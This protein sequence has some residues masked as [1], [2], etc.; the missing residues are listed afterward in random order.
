VKVQE[1]VATSLTS[2]RQIPDTRECGSVPELTVQSEWGGVEL[3]EAVAEE[4]RQLCLEG[5]C[6]QPF[7]RPEWIA[8][9]IRAFAGQQGLLLITARNGD[10]LRAVLP[11]L[12]HRGWAYG[13][14]CVRLRTA[15]R[16]PRFEFVHG[17][18]DGSEAVRAV[19]QHLR[20]LPGWDVIELVNVPEGGAAERLLAA[21]SEDAFP[22]S[23]HEY[24]LSPYIPLKGNVAGGDF[25]RFGR[26]SRFRYQLRQKWRELGELGALRL[27]RTDKADPETLQRFYRL[28]QS[29]WKGREGSAILCKPELRQFYD[30]VARCAEKFGYLSIYFLELGDKDVAAHFALTYGGGYYPI[31]VAYD[32]K[33]SKYG[34]GHLIIGSVLN[35][36]VA[37]GLS[38]FDCLGEKNAALTKWTSAVHVYNSCSIFRNSVR[39]RMLCAASGLQHRSKQAL[40]TAIRS[41]R[42]LASRTKRWLSGPPESRPEK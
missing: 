31:K 3:V 12:E 34:P 5:P 2:E 9:A 36:C 37:C 40:R 32:E 22:A 20:N 41:A 26:S 11:L 35:E 17:D 42:S 28:E 33:F 1:A 19:W 4:W 38:E 8:A 16:I 21:A 10:R 6:N 7:Y 39:G 25:W 24:A 29:G 15:S 18:T 23:R 27:Q 14:P 13:V 30:G